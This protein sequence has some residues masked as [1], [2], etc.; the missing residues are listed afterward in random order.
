MPLPLAVDAMAP[1]LHVPDGPPQPVLYCVAGSLEDATKAMYAL[2]QDLHELIGRTFGE[3][4]EEAKTTPRPVP[5]GSIGRIHVLLEDIHGLI[6]ECQIAAS[7]LAQL[8]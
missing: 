1:S 6:T 2:K 7:R 5:A 4:I 8:S 3:G